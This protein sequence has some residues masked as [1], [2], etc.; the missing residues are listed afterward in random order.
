MERRRERRDTRYSI[1]YG[2][3]ELRIALPTRYR[4]VEYLPPSASTAQHPP[5]SDDD[6]RATIRHFLST[7]RAHPVAASGEAFSI[8]IA[9]N[10]GSRPPIQHRLLPLLIPELQRHFASQHG[11]RAAAP[12]ILLCI[13]NGL[14]RPPSPSQVAALIPARYLHRCRVVN[15]DAKDKDN[16]TFLG[17]SPEG[18]PVWVNSAFHAASYRLSISAVTG[19]QFAGVTGGGKC[20][21]IGLAG[22]ETITHNHS[23]YSDPRA[24]AG[25]IT[26]NPVRR[27]IDEIARMMGVDGS[28]NCALNMRNKIIGAQMIATERAGGGAAATAEF[29][30]F[31]TEEM[32]RCQ[33]DSRGGYDGVFVGGGGYPRDCNLYQLQKALAHVA[34]LAG[35]QSPIILCGACNEG[36]GDERFQAHFSSAASV[37]EVLARQPTEPFHIGPH[38]SVLFARDMQQRSVGLI[39]ELAPRLVRTLHFTPLRPRRAARFLAPSSSTGRPLRIAVI[40]YPTHCYFRVDHS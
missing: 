22:E 1:P 8:A 20:A 17:H 36:V 21:A 12:N 37:A 31:A 18:S 14:H 30:R 3:E 6:L 9:I 27:D 33:I 24:R 15:H 4:V 26:D 34:P 32:R 29:H 5:C 10:D 28:L 23:L 39:S 35:A 16:L 40:P 2:R 7:Q 13:A 25:R 11:A 19:H 38:K